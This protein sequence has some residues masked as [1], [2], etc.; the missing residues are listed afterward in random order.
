VASVVELVLVKKCGIELLRN[1][2]EEGRPG[3]G[4]VVL[5]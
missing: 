5:S 3:T 1:F 4:K 2:G